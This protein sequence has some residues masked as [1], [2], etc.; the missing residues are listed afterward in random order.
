M[1]FWGTSWYPTVVRCAAGFWC[2]DGS[3]RNTPCP[4]RCHHDMRSYFWKGTST[5]TQILIYIYNYIHTVKIEVCDSNVLIATPKANTQINHH[6]ISRDWLLYLGGDL[7]FYGQPQSAY[8]WSPR[9][10]RLPCPRVLATSGAKRP[11]PEK[12]GGEMW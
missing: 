7:V 11:D 12:P 5:Y 8:H 3:K 2:A 1:G 4:G 10:C 6:Q 9:P